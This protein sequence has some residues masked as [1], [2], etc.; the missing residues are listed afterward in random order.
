MKKLKIK[1]SVYIYIS[2]QQFSENNT[3]IVK[4]VRY[5]DMYVDIDI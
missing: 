1:K 2:F 3:I 5:Y 4:L